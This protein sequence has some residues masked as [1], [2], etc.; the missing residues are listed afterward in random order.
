MI[1]VG[2]IRRPHGLDGEV[3]VEVRTDFP[4]RFV[5]GAA[6]VW[7]RGEQTRSLVLRSVRAHSGRLLMRFDG[8]EDVEEAATLSGGDLCVAEGEAVEP[9]DD[10]YYGHVVEGWSCRDSHGR[11]LGTVTKLEQTPAGPMLELRTPAGRT[12]LVPFVRPIVVSVDREAGRI[13]LD[14]PEGLF[15][16]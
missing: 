6:L 10:F 12:C 13:V 1:L 11:E 7:R 2:E 9:P 15:D 3:S 5:P 14:P 4:E 8:I 16:L